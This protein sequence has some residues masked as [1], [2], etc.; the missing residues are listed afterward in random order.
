[1]KHLALFVALCASIVSSAQQAEDTLRFYHNTVTVSA[2]ESHDTISKVAGPISVIKERQLKFGNEGSAESSLNLIP[3][4]KMEER[5]VGGSR[6]LNIRGSAIRAPFGVRN[7]RAYIGDFSI[8]SP[9][10]S[11]PLE[12]IDLSALESI[13]VVKGPSS[14]IYGAGTGGAIIFN[15][16]VAQAGLGRLELGQTLGSYGFDRTVAKAEFGFK[17]GY[18]MLGYINQVYAGYRQQES[19]NKDQINVLAG[20]KTSE[21]GSIQMMAYHFN[22]GWGL[23]G[24]IDSAAVANNPTQADGYSQDHDA[25]LKRIRTRVGLGVQQKF[26]KVVNVKVNG[27]GNFTSKENPYGTNPFFQGWKR[28]HGQ[29]FGVR[30]ITDWNILTRTNTKVAAIVGTEYQTEL[31]LLREYRNELGKPGSLKFDNETTSEQTLAFADV[32]LKTHGWVI[33]AGVSFNRLNYFNLNLY[34]QDS[35]DLTKNIKFKPT[36]SPRFTVLKSIRK[37]M[38][39]H[40]SASWGFSPPTLWEVVSEAGGV[41]TDLKPETGLNLEL[42]LRGQIS[43]FLFYDVSGYVMQLSN[44]IVPRSDTNGVEFFENSGRTDQYGVELQLVYSAFAPGSRKQWNELTV[45][46]AYA[47]QNYRFQNYIT[48]SDTLSGNN[49]PGVAPHSLNITARSAWKFGL[50]TELRYRFVD[51]VYLNDKNTDI[52]DPYH[53]LDLEVGYERTLLKRLKVK[54]FGGVNNLLNESYSSYYRLNGFG[55]KY[56]NPSAPLNWYAGVRLSYAFN[57]TKKASSNN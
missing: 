27:Y 15:P 6:R 18:L 13:E 4:V 21:T 56:Y 46:A 2:F 20:W 17:N 3:G 52:A 34:N 29:G 39:I 12:V 43:D 37:N 7:V 45:T 26:G 48:G 49:L 28:E 30:A 53:L 1:M 44:T 16:A 57:L 47:F 24:A 33:S 22:G 50:Y 35:V 32:R 40:G 38:A 10:G 23:A 31:N 36:F 14:S 19:V 8:T 54:A 9:D 55:G 51:Q 5:G 25:H 11:T 41:N 42:G